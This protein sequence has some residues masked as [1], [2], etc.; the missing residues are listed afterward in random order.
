[1]SYLHRLQNL[2]RK[3]PSAWLQA[4]LARI[5]GQ[6]IKTERFLRIQ[7]DGYPDFGNP[8]PSMGQIRLVGPEDI[9]ALTGCVDKR[10]LFLRRFALGEYCVAAFDGDRVVGY[11]WFSARP[12]HVEERY[13]YS[14]DIPSGALY[15][16]DGFVAESHRNRGIWR[17]MIQAAID[18]MKRENR[19][20]L[21]AH[22]AYDNIAWA[23]AHYRLGYRLISQFRY[24]E[25]FGK[26]FLTEI[27]SI[28]SNS[29]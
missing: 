15:C 27:P 7:L 5:P 8:S 28:R 13:W 17:A 23:D 24:L 19:H 22:V 29:V 2:A 1:M 14:F 6:P 3:G 9:E 26:Q 12:K 25:F 11:E 10:A 21:I 18:I 4:V 16:Y 20:C